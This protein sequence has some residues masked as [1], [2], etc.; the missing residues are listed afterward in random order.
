MK[1]IKSSIVQHL[2]GSW[3]NSK[4]WYAFL[5]IAMF[6]AFCFRGFIAG[7][8]AA[9]SWFS[10]LYNAKLLFYSWS[11]YPGL[12]AY[13]PNDF[14]SFFLRLFYF[15]VSFYTNKPE[16]TQK[17]AWILFFSL[18]GLISM[19]CVNSF[20]KKRF[21]A[22]ISIL[23][24]FFNPVSQLY[25]WS[26][27]QWSY[28]LLFPYFLGVY[29]YLMFC[30]TGKFA[31]LT[32]IA[33]LWFFFGFAF[34]QPAYFAPFLLI[35]LVTFLYMFPAAKNKKVFFLQNLFFGIV[36]I[37]INF[38]YIFPL[39]IGGSGLLAKTQASYGGEAMPILN[40][41]KDINFFYSFINI[42][43]GYGVFYTHNPVVTGIWV[44]FFLVLFYYAFA[45]AKNLFYKDTQTYMLLFGILLLVFIFFTKGISPPFSG[46]SAWVY[47]FKIMYIFRGFKEKFAIGYSITITC[48][49]ICLFRQKN[50]FVKMFLV[51]IA[52]AS[53]AA[54]IFNYWYPAQLRYS[55]NLTYLSAV[56][57]PASNV[58]RVLNLPLVS[59]SFFYT[60]KPYYVGDNPLKNIFKK[61]VLYSSSQGVSDVRTQWIKTGLTQKK[62]SGRDFY[63]YLQEY[64]IEYVLN[65]KNSSVLEEHGVGYDYRYAATYPFLQKISETD[66][67]ILYRFKDFLPRIYAPDT[68][69]HQISPVAYTI[70]VRHLSNPRALWFLDSFDPGWKLYVPQAGNTMPVPGMKTIFDSSHT[71]V[72]GY[73]NGWEINPADIK[74][75]YPK[76]L[77]TVNRDGSINLTL[78]LYFY[79]Q[80]YFYE[81]L[82]VSLIALG[83]SIFYLL[84]RKVRIWRFI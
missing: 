16:I 8:D 20:V 60:R 27:Q 29:L 68:S 43:K 39:A 44:G 53:Y 64:N 9:S 11:T 35:L 38:V 31:Y 52:L 37:L 40:D 63:R 15:S 36:F 30:K 79:P 54:F 22:F 26:Q 5:P 32:G 7:S 45:P 49:F 84:W 65:N 42:T 77:Y 66:T 12:G 47:H 57:F 3:T 19:Y 69:F 51:L 80:L 34:N 71:L 81:G 75:T 41:L 21:Y 62:L 2:G 72:K 56:R 74:H 76:A 18:T 23:F 10:P 1:K 17:A 13:L 25:L 55:D 78:L 6:F 73:A 70:S 46:I 4:L 48:L 28:Y 61:D 59:Y 50:V 58:S 33:L 82:A 24:L 67:Y 14:T 83:S